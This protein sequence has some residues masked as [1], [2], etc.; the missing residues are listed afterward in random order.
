MS[1]MQCYGAWKP[2]RLLLKPATV[3]ADSEP[4]EPSVFSATTTTSECTT[5]P[6]ARGDPV[7]SHGQV[8]TRDLEYPYLE[9]D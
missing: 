5:S 7:P 2:P 3:E 6:L 1:Q 8:F 9:A 4:R